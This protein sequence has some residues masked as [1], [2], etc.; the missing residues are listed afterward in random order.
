MKLLGVSTS[1]LH[2]LIVLLTILTI[3][4]SSALDTVLAE[5][6]QQT[7]NASGEIPRIVAFGNSLTAGL[8]V[9]PDETYPAHLQQHLDRSG[10]RYRVVNAGVSGDTTA[11]GLRRVAW[12]LKSRPQVVILELGGN[13]GLRGL[14]LSETRSNLETIIQ[15]FREAS[16]T[17][18]LAGIQLPPNYG[19]EYTAGFQAIYPAL[20]KKYGL[21]FIPFILEGVAGSVTLNQ[22]DGI[23]PTGEGYQIIAQHVFEQLE[24]LLS[25]GSP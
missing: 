6:T 17:V 2:H 4:Q 3:Y 22:A 24:P 11:G 10:I 12:I 25:E 20:A 18:V 7:R 1:T 5:S 8:G 23:H 15:K 19:K 9:S 14:S 21:V 13:D 16:V